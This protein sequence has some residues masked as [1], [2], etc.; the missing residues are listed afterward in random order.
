NFFDYI[1]FNN[2][3]QCIPLEQE[4]DYILECYRKLKL[5]GKVILNTRV[6][7]DES[8][9]W[10][11]FKDNENIVYKKKNCESKIKKIFDSLTLKVENEFLIDKNTFYLL[12][13]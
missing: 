3:W 7:S 13:K 6:A 9:K 4:Q 8:Q 1:I 12:T 2:Y 11:E 5:D 10:E